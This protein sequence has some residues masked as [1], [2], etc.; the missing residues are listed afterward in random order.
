MRSGVFARV[1][2]AT[3]LCACGGARPRSEEPAAEAQV[4]FADEAGQA[5]AEIE[6]AEAALAGDHADDAKRTL[7]EYLAGAGRADKRGWLDLGLALEMLGDTDSAR[8]AYEH[9]IT[10]DPNY[11]MALNNLGVIERDADNLPIARTYFERA[12]VARPRFATAHHNLAMTLEDLDDAAGARAHYLQVVEL[13][14]ESANACTSLGLLELRA[15]NR[16]GA[17]IWY[18]RAA[19]HAT[20]TADLYVLGSGLRQAGDPD[21]AIAILQ[22]AITESEDAPPIGL[23]A[24]LA[25]ARFAAGQRELAKADLRALIRLEPRNGNLQH[26]L[27]NMLAVE[28]EWVDA[29]RA[30]EAAI[31]AGEPGVEAPLRAARSALG[32]SRT[33]RVNRKRSWG[34]RAQTGGKGGPLSRI[35]LCGGKVARGAGAPA[36][37]GGKGGSDLALP[38]GGKGPSPL[39]EK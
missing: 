23:R 28:Q 36:Q 7:D 18:R 13:V 11:A 34:P 3:V 8:A 26:L 22:R 17:L 12:L 24:E 10:I 21:M 5:A 15:G 38:V 31:A 1:W 25:L 16:E 35:A 19:A 29:V 27:G 20:G 37:T 30:Y 33:S 32:R 6:S 2:L 14:P 4:T 39:P 9:A